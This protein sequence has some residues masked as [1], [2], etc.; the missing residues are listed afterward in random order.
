MEG[1]S[2]S[3]I[4]QRR[5]TPKKNEKANGRKRALKNRTIANNPAIGN[6]SRV[7]SKYFP[8]DQKSAVHRQIGELRKVTSDGQ[9]EREKGSRS[10]AKKLGQLNTTR[11]R[12]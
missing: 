10:R 2:V 4:P 12:N 3:T 7:K 8:P 5:H 11:L 9:G 1:S 6:N